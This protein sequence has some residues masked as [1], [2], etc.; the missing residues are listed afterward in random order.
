MINPWH[1]LFFLNPPRHAELFWLILSVLSGRLQTVSS[2]WS[3]WSLALLLGRN[4]ANFQI[5][6]CGR[7]L[8]AQNLEGWVPL[9]EDGWVIECVKPNCAV[10][11]QPKVIIKTIRSAKHSSYV[12]I[13]LHEQSPPCSAETLM[14]LNAH[15]NFMHLANH[16]KHLIH[17]GLI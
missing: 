10:I 3:W 4:S 17:K 13:A 5:D 7:T 9:Q 1:C 16:S 11:T 2:M 14:S 12:M 15:S 8:K 6:A